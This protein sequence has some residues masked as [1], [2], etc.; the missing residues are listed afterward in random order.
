MPVKLDFC[1]LECQNLYC[2]IDAVCRATENREVDDEDT[3]PGLGPS[4]KN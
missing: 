1:S 3:N 4:L 2:E